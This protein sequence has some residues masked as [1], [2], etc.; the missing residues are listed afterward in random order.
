[1]V[2]V[3]VFLAAAPTRADDQGAGPPSAEVLGFTVPFRV[4]ML[5]AEKT[6]RIAAL[7]VQRGA[8]VGAGDLLVSLSDEVQRTRTEMARRKAK[9]T[10]EI[11]L[12]R[13]RM[14]RAQRELQRLQRLTGDSAV[15]SKELS[16]AQAAFDAMEIEYGIAR[17]NHEQD[18][19][20]FALQSQMLDKLVIRAPF[21]GYVRELHK[22]IGETVEE[23][24][25]I[26]ELAQLHPLLVVVDCPLNVAYELEEGA[27][28]RVRSAD[29]HWEPRW[30]S[31][32]LVG[33]VAD[34][35]SQTIRVKLLVENQDHAWLAGLKVYVDVGGPRAALAG[36]E[37]D[38]ED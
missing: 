2:I 12:A 5:A 13:V 37:I 22:E 24:E 1:M 34:A 7:P 38:R 21:D 15:A 17:L 8:F 20:D 32:L 29:A 9:S 18:V 26:V 23:G 4:A 25:G 19:L 6:E 10:L 35:A 30:A 11:D 33:R 14:E 28:V 31:V 16:D 27:R 3:A 36:G